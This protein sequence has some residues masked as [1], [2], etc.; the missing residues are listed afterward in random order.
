MKPVLQQEQGFT[1]V[2]VIIAII[3]LTIGLLGLVASSALVTRMIARGQRSAVQT[4]FATRRLEMARATACTNQGG[5]TEV[6]LRA[7][8]AVDS[9]TWRFVNRGNSTWQ[10]IIRS[11]YQTDRGRWRTDSTETE[12]SCII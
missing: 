3:V 2:E 7:G 5:G 8:V 1:V 10:I 12:V 4:V 9:L 11:K 6:L